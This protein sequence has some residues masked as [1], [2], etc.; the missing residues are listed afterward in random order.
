MRGGT[1]KEGKGKGELTNIGNNAFVSRRGRG[2]EGR[3]EK[4]LKN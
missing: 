2:V 3:A 1:E 4:S